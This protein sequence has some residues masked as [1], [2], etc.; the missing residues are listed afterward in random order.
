MNKKNLIICFSITVLILI[1]QS[2][3]AHAALNVASWMENNDVTLGITVGESA[4]FDYGVTAVSCC[5][6]TGAYSIKLYREGIS[7]PIYTYIEETPTINNGAT[8]FLTVRPS[9]YGN[10]A[11]SYYVIIYSIDRYGSD[12]FRLNLNVENIMPSLAV[13]CNSNPTSGTSP[14]NVVFT[15]TTNGGTG[16]YTYTWTFGDGTTSN[17]IGTTTHTYYNQGT[18]T[19]TLTVRDSQNSQ[20]TTN[21]GLITVSDAQYDLIA[22]AGGP[23]SGYIHESVTLDASASFGSLGI[24]SYKWDF[25][26]FTSL[27]STNPIIQHTYNNIGRHDVTLTVYD[28]SGHSRSDTTYVTVTERV[29]Y[30]SKIYDDSADNG[31]IV[32]SM[33][34][35]GKLGE[36]IQPT[37]D[38]TVQLRLENVL[39]WKLEDVRVTVSIPDLGLNARSSLFDLSSGED[40]STSVVLPIYNI[41]AGTY[42]VKISIDNDDN[43]EQVRRVKYRDI[44]VEDCSGVAQEGTG[45]N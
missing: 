24:V 42:S 23:Y 30:T 39:D 4:Q 34:L 40:Y 26:D 19:T 1:L 29:N 2:G 9:D 5:G 36:I 6:S 44:I 37:D 32:K 33:I 43:G 13:S 22:E 38:L 21:C 12:S 27:E 10:M 8:G 14:L 35:Y 41:S 15:S 11:G 3:T 28:A 31:I 17:S 25:G 16:S 18:Y 7:T 45:C 20:T